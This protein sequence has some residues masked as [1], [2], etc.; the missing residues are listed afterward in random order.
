VQTALAIWHLAGLRSRK[1]D[2]RLTSQTLELFGIKDRSAKYRGLAA[3][4][5]AGLISV[6]RETGKNPLVTILEV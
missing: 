5:K 1:H 4:E 3:L 2:L 6:Q